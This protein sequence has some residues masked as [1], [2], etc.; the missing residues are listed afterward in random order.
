MTRIAAIDRHSGFVWGVT[1]AGSVTGAALAI[2]ADADG[3]RDYTVETCG[4]SD[5]D[6]S[7]DLYEVAADLEIADGQDAATIAAVESSRYLATVR[8]SE[9]G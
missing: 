5:A 4:R 2:L 6:A 1:D 8:S 9:I 3:S 7:L